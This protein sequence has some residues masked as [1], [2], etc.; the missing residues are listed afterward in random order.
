MRQRTDLPTNITSEVTRELLCVLKACQTPSETGINDS[1]NPKLISCM[2]ICRA[3]YDLKEKRLCCSDQVWLCLLNHRAS[4]SPRGKIWKATEA[5][6]DEQQRGRSCHKII[7]LPPKLGADE[8]AYI[9]PTG[10]LR[11]VSRDPHCCI[12]TQLR[13]SSSQG[14]ESE[15]AHANGAVLSCLLKEVNEKPMAVFPGEWGSAFSCLAAQIIH[16]RT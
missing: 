3:S 4:F 15:W 16:P 5:A 13:F 11:W 6:S 9:N 10:V 7:A 12:I 8:I 14:P 1:I 2:F